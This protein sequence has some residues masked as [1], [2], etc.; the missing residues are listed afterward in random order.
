[1]AQALYRP[2]PKKQLTGSALGGKNCN[3]SAAAVLADRDTLGIVNVT[4][5]A[6]RKAS[7][8]TVGGTD[9]GGAVTALAK[10]G[11]SVNVFDGNDGRTWADVITFLKSGRAVSASGVYSEVPLA[12]RGD[13][14]FT[15]TH[16]VYFNEV[17][18]SGRVLCYDGLDD[19]RYSGI[20]KAPIWWPGAVARDFMAAFPGS[21][22]T[23]LA[24]KR[25]RAVVKVDVANIRSGPSVDS[26][27]IATAKVGQSFYRGSKAVVGGAVGNNRVWHPVWVPALAKVGYMHS[28]IVTLA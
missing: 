1:M 7:G 24:A 4:A 25:R 12:L 16:Q 18:S 9:Q 2:R 22:L 10:Y 13:K 5:D 3:M 8:D 14:D 6:M 15:G 27:V 11:I 19:G 26:P 23:F 21:G 20:P 28:S 17:D